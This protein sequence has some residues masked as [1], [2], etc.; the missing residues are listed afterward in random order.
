[1]LGLD[2]LDKGVKIGEVR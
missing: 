1:V 2:I